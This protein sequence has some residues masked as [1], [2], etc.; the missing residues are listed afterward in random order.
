VSPQ[1]VYVAALRLMVP[2]VCAR[3]RWSQEGR[4]MRQSDRSISVGRGD[5]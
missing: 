3:R 2:R 1:G 5:G 4:A